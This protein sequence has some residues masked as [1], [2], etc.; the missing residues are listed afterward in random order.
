MDSKALA[1]GLKENSTL[2]NLDLHLNQIGAEGA[3]AWRLVRIVGKKRGIEEGSRHSQLKVKS[4]KCSQSLKGMHCK[5]D[6]C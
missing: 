2:K 5:V 3:K 1:E 6:L 4:V